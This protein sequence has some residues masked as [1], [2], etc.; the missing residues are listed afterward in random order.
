MG[1]S[2]SSS[3]APDA[4]AKQ[5]DKWSPLRERMV[6]TQIERRGVRDPKV[7]AAMRKVPRHLFV[8]SRYRK[9]S[10]DDRPLPIGQSQT[11]SQPYVVAKMTELL[12]LKG[13]E[14]VLEIGTGSGYQA[15]VLAE[16]AGEVFTIEIVPEL[17]KSA[18]KLLE[19]MGYK[20]IH[21]MV[22]DGYK[23][24]PEAAPFDA[25][26]VTA[27]PPYIPQPLVDQLKMGARMVLPVG[28]TFQELIV[29]TRTKKGYDTRKVF[30][31]RF[32]P[33]TGEVQKKAPGK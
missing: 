2:P 20:N 29:V 17:G 11:I 10:Y 21:V 6:K 7:L 27:A 18:K 8:P 19:K 25:I 9:D 4:H 26:I 33:M 28:E 30:A 16:I 24:W 3:I 31:V 5:S 15:A 23:G 13:G 12:E 22:G 32:V 1:D 14:K